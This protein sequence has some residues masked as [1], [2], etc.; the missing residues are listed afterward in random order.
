M[1]PGFQLGLVEY[2]DAVSLFAKYSSS[3]PP[4]SHSTLSSEL[5]DC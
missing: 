4:T 3:P 2:L 1:K 5:G